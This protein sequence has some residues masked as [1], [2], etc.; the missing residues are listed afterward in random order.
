MEKQETV[1]MSIHLW[2]DK[3]IV[4]RPYNGILLGN[5]KK[6][7]YWHTIW[8]NFKSIMLSERSQTQG[9]YCVTPYSW[10][11]YDS[12]TPY[13]RLCTVWLPESLE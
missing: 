4:V 11:P 9:P 2:M 5:K 8:M 13:V 7:K 3:Q 10:T 12:M 1:Q 6:Q